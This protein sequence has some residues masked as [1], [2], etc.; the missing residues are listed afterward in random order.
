[1]RFELL[2]AARVRHRRRIECTHDSIDAV[3]GIAVDTFQAP[4][5]DPLDQKINSGHRSEALSL[6][7]I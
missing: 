3:A 6:R 2:E 5:V 7:T 4:L 1:M